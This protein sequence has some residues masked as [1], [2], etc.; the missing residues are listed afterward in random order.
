MASC[1][2][3]RQGIDRPGI[4]D[5]NIDRRALRREHEQHRRGD[6][7]PG[8]QV[9]LGPEI[10]SEGEN[11]LKR[12]MLPRQALGRRRRG[13]HVSHAP[14][15][16]RGAVDSKD[17]P[18]LAGPA[19]ARYSA[20]ITFLGGVCTTGVSSGAPNDCARRSFPTGP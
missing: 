2:G 14:D 10:R 20:A 18:R 6:T 5:R 9:A 13:A 12:G 3:L 4:Q 8:S 1:P 17:S 11:D 16:A 15:V 7:C 19:A